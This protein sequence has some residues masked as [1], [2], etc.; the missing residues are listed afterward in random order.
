MF[1]LGIGTYKGNLRNGQI[2]G[3]GR[4]EYLNGAIY[5]GEWRDNRKQGRGK[6][7]DEQSVHTGLWDNDLKHGKGT[8]V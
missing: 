7:L 4:F 3:H 8:F 5:E 1:F 2:E 6:L